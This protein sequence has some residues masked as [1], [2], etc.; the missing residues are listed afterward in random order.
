MKTILSTLFCLLLA[1]ASSAADINITN[2]VLASGL[3]TNDTLLGVTNGTHT[4]RAKVQQVIDLASQQIVETGTN[5]VINTTNLNYYWTTN[6]TYTVITNTINNTT[7]LNYYYSTNVT[8]TFVTNLIGLTNYLSPDVVL[9][10]AVN[11]FSNNNEFQSGVQFNSTVTATN[12]VLIGGKLNIGSTGSVDSTNQFE[13]HALGGM[14]NVGTNGVLYG[15]GVVTSITNIVNNTTNLNYYWT[16]NVT[17]QYFTNLIASNV[18]NLAASNGIVINTNGQLY[19]LSVSNNYS[20]T[21]WVFDPFFTNFVA[22]WVISNLLVWSNA[23]FFATELPDYSVWGGV[24]STGGYLSV[25]LGAFADGSTNGVGVGYAAH[26]YNNGVG[27]GINAEGQGQGNV[28]VG[29]SANA[30]SALGFEN[31]AEIGTGTATRDGWLHYRGQP[32]VDPLGNF[33]ATAITNLA[34]TASRIAIHDANQKIV[35]ATASGSVPIDADGS[36]TT[37][38]QI[39]NL[40]PITLYNNISGSADF[41]S[42]NVTN[43]WKVDATNSQSAAVFSPTMLYNTAVV[44]VIDPTNNN[45]QYIEQT[46]ASGLTIAISTGIGVGDMGAIELNISNNTALTLTFL[47]TNLYSTFTYTATNNDV[48]TVLFWKPPY[49]SNNLWRAKQLQ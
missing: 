30:G 34:A 42:S 35:S 19:T 36:A 29:S 7:N 2:I 26:G 41:V 1:F 33:Y 24:G 23:Q 16:T 31:T 11:I 49:A 25:S 18:F 37:A 46:N 21:N 38:G 32:I 6:V 17:I 48:G 10:S 28:A 15:A 9:K 4:A 14:V 22:P 8:F 5:I 43:R 13:V 20:T 47:T 39:T 3:S 44:A 40:L 12:H 27:V 45:L